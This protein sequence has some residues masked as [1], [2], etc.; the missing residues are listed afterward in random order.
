MQVWISEVSAVIFKVFFVGRVGPGG[1]T[2]PRDVRS[3]ADEAKI[4]DGGERV[5]I[6]H[7]YRK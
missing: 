1:R 5:A 4:G 3:V 6:M 7:D 2:S